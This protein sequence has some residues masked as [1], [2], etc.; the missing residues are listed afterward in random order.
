[1]AIF[2]VG[3][4][5]VGFL[6]VA[7]AAAAFFLVTLRP[8]FMFRLSMR[9]CADRS[10]CLPDLSPAATKRELEKHQIAQEMRRK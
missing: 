10:I 7:G 5:V 9:C 3:P 1:L 4:D 8:M 6:A 2:L